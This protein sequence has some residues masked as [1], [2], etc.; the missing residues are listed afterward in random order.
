LIRLNVMLTDKQVV[1]IIEKIKYK[2]NFTL[3]AY[4]DKDAFEGSIVRLLIRMRVPDR[5]LRDV[6]T[7]VEN[8]EIY[9]QI[10]CDEEHV[11][12]TVRKKLH[13]MERHESDEMFIYEGERIFDPHKHEQGEFI[14]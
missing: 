13:D 3:K 1:N 7:N 9:D 6:L 8:T 11:L 14:T 10:F 4:A 12:D 5:N 2:D